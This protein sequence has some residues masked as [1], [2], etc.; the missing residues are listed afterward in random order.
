MSVTSKPAKRLARTSSVIG[1][2]RSAVQHG[3]ASGEA[4]I[5]HGAQ[6]RRDR[7]GFQGV[8]Y[9]TVKGALSAYDDVFADYRAF[10]RPRLE[11]AHRLLADDGDGKLQRWVEF[12]GLDRFCDLYDKGDLP[13]FHKIVDAFIKWSD[14]ILAWHDTRRVSNSRIEGIN[15]LIQNLR[16]SAFGFTN[17]E[18]LQARTLPTA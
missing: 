11:Q 2:H 17:P 12:V 9:R 13:E 10:L 4:D 5:A 1:V 8:A 16:R 7:V 3:L 14:E 18:N 6:H 15:N